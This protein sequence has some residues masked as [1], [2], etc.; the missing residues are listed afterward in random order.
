MYTLTERRFKK[1]KSILEKYRAQMLKYKII[2]AMAL[3]RD[4]RDCWDTGYREIKDI[5]IQLLKDERYVYLAA[6]FMENS[7]SSVGVVMEF[8]E[9]LAT[10]YG[11]KSFYHDKNYKEK[12]DAFWN[13]FKE[14]R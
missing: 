1:A 7:N 3:E 9:P 2:Q 13:A 4:L 11:A 5:M 10:L 8:Q 14:K 6:Y 12:R